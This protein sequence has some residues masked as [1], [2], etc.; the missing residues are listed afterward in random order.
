MPRRLLLL[1][2]AEIALLTGAYLFASQ[3]IAHGFGF[4]LDDSWIY[5]VF[6]R[7]LAEGR[8]LVYNPGQ[9][10]SPTGI[11]YGLLLGGLYRI[12]V[13]PIAMAVISGFLLHLGAA[14]LVYKT[15]RLLELGETLS[16]GCAI[17]LAAVPRLIW[18][19]LSG[20]EVPLYV[21]LVCLGLYWQ[22]RWR[23]YDG[24]RAYLATLAFGLAALARPECG[25]F[26]VVSVIE[27]LVN[28]ARF[29]SEKGGAGRYIRTI[30]LHLLVFVLVALPAV[31]FNLRATGLPM[32]PAFYAK[33]GVPAVAGIAGLVRQCVGNAGAYVHQALE[34]SWRD[35]CILLIGAV[36]GCAFLRRW[37]STPSRA[38]ALI[39][40]LAFVLVP[41]ATGVLAHKGTGKLQL[42]FQSGRYSD[43]LAPVLVLMAM[44]GAALLC[45][46]VDRRD[47]WR[48]AGR[49]ALVGA[50]TCAVWVF[51][52]NNWSMA[53]KYA[54]DVRSIDSM[55]VVIGKWAAR[56]PAGVALAVND[57]GAIPYFSRKRIID[58]VGVT[59][60]EVIPYLRKYRN[61]QPGLLEYL[62]KRRPDY[63][64]IFPDWYGKIAC[65]RDLL[66]PVMVVKLRG[67][68]VCGGNVM[69]VYR[70]TWGR[71]APTGARVPSLRK[72][73]CSRREQAQSR[74]RSPA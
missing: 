36:V 8:G 25:A 27:R 2:A 63:L 5:A 47:S 68:T 71:S 9:P 52:L 38:R 62:M 18:G 54:C 65:R 42:I 39:L 60:P 3:R 10:V 17:L 30:P 32:P 21:F 41:A 28:S 51:A 1:V 61:R 64:I 57:A 6:A 33:T 26:L 16:A 29:D 55:Q 7:N 66:R 58:T 46:V 22:V 44:V 72:S 15:A 70:S 14:A 56:L 67:D 37:V 50:A 48:L 20:M 59:D 4:P 40:P 73:N 13:A 19:V 11:L 45:D 43:Y 74:P 24:A 69:I 49:L 34:V 35:N 12:S 23:W 31:V 53:G